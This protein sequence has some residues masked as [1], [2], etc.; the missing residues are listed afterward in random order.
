[1]S[2]ILWQ[3]QSSGVSEDKDH[4]CSPEENIPP[5]ELFEMDLMDLVNECPSLK[6]Q[7]KH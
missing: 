3:E 6:L 1:M 7:K 5:K 4:L 2:V